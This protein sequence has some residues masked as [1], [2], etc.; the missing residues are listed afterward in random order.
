MVMLT[1]YVKATPIA[2]L[3][4][5]HGSTIINVIVGAVGRSAFGWHTA[6]TIPNGGARKRD[7]RGFLMGAMRELGLGNMYRYWPAV[8]EQDL[9]HRE[10]NSF[11]N[12]T[13][14]NN[15]EGLTQARLSTERARQKWKH[16]PPT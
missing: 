14:E 3:A 2:R 12:L 16:R 4:P 15:D 9:S 1:T 6:P 7:E 11:G 8:G 5:Q 10:I 13:I